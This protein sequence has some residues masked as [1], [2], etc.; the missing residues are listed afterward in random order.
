MNTRNVKEVNIRNSSQ[1]FEGNLE[2]EALFKAKAVKTVNM[3]EFK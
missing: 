3:I 1:C 2:A